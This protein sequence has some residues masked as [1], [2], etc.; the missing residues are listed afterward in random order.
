ME[1]PHAA[2]ALQASPVLWAQ[3]RE[4]SR[5]SVEQAT[6]LW[7]H[8]LAS[9]DS[10]QRAVS[11]RADVDA[12]RFALYAHANDPDRAAGAT[13][14]LARLDDRTFAAAVS[15]A[16][17]RYGLSRLER[18]AAERAV[19]RELAVGDAVGAR[20]WPYASAHPDAWGT[21][22]KG[23]L[24]AVNDP[25]AW[26]GNPALRSQQAI[27]QQAWCHEHGSLADTVPVLWDFGDRQAVFFQSVARDDRCHALRPYADDCRE[28]E[29][30]YA[31]ACRAL[32][33]RAFSWCAETA[34]FPRQAA[35]NGK[36]ARS[37]THELARG[38]RRRRGGVVDRRTAG[39]CRERNRSKP[40]GAQHR[41]SSSRLAQQ[42]SRGG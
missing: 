15:E 24:L 30:A 36:R 3:L 41:P 16:R 18:D 33:R 27:D 25:R 42:S 22:W 4:V 10:V 39:S 29:A 6:A 34:N 2:A 26:A 7:Q 14:L 5:S 20:R 37:G 35:G 32:I 23:I 13:H 8:A 28:W 12:R 31:A 19:S 9:E 11:L 40:V 21:P 1:K 38:L 17:Q